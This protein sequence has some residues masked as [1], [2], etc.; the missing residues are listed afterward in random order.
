MKHEGLQIGLAD[1][2]KDG[3]GR[4][5][6][7]ALMTGWYARSGSVLDFINHVLFANLFQ[8]MI[9][10]LYLFYNYIVT[11]QLVAAE[12]MRFSHEKKALRVSSPVNEC[13]RSEYFLSLPWKYAAPQ[14]ASFMLLHWLVSQSVFIVQTTAYGPGPSGQ[15][16]AS[17]DAS[18]I[19]FSSIGILLSTL[20]GSVMLFILL[21]NSFVRSYPS[22]PPDM[23]RM[24]TNSAAISAACHRPSSD[25][26]AHL[27]PVRFGAVCEALSTDTEVIRTI[28]FST[29]TQMQ[30]PVNGVQYL[31]PVFIEKDKES[32]NTYRQL[33]IALSQILGHISMITSRRRAHRKSPGPS[34]YEGT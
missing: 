4:T 5:N 2:W 8:L 24:A 32:G 26:D 13:Q 1:L 34:S 27:L 12:W 28:S 17:N 29:D 19:G 15:R 10:V 23:A 25:T 20:W 18:R 7:Y 21:L 9:S 11:C 30:M 6:G 22:F 3:L 16:I 33:K 31:Q 14:M